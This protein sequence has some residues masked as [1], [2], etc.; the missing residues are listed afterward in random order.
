MGGEDGA[1]V[2]LQDGLLELGDGGAV[3]ELAVRLHQLDAEQRVLVD[4][5]GLVGARVRHV[6]VRHVADADGELAHVLDELDVL[7]QGL[8]D[9]V[10]EGVL[11]AE[12]REPGQGHAPLGARDAFEGK[13]PRRRPQERWDRR[14]EEVAEAVGDGYCRLQMPLRLAL[15]VRETAA[16][17]RV[18]AVGGG[19]VPL[20][21]FQRIPGW[22]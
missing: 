14:L 10:V 9:E 11:E 6:H 22:G 20:P 15:A 8:L 3:R 18:G 13:G 2:Q 21:P 4:A 12:A 1:V 5:V 7:P 16:G 17:H 19:G